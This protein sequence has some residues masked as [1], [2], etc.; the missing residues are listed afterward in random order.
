MSETHETIAIEIACDVPG[1][2]DVVVCT[3]A[4]GSSVADVLECSGL[5]ARYP[6]LSW[7]PLAVGVHGRVVEPSRRVQPGDR[8]EIYRPL[9][10]DPKLARR[11]R[12]KREL[13]LPKPAVR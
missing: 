4:S 12:V 2:V 3:V 1:G 9:Q 13:R 11:Q 10:A 8:V 6:Q 5:R 7:P